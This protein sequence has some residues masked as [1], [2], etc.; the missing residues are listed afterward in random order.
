MRLTIRYHEPTCE[1]WLYLDDRR[2]RNGKRPS[3][4]NYTDA[5]IAVITKLDELR[6]TRKVYKYFQQHPDE[7]H[8][9]GFVASSREIQTTH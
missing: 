5:W 2:V 8:R 9:A 7:A 1:Y 4:E 6:D 3:P